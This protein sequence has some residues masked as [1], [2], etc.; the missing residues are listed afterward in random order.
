MIK[1]LTKIFNIKAKTRPKPVECVKGNSIEPEII[2]EEDD[3][4]DSLIVNLLINVL[5]QLPQGCHLHIWDYIYWAF[6]EKDLLHLL[7]FGGKTEETDYCFNLTEECIAYLKEE[8]QKDPRYIGLY[9]CHYY[10]EHEGHLLLQ[11]F[12]NELITV[13]TSIHIPDEIINTGIY[14]NIEDNI[15]KW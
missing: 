5:E 15:K 7:D 4:R 6:E 2:E 12:D 8:L 3:D 11:V 10:I 14:L 13:H 9:F 1:L